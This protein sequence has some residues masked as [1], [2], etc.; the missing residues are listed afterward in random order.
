MGEDLFLSQ[1]KNMFSIH[2]LC[3]NEI[4][5]VE[6]LREV[7]SD[8]IGMGIILIFKKALLRNKQRHS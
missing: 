8:L 4:H 5:F 3:F 2:S 7:L 6:Y 1:E